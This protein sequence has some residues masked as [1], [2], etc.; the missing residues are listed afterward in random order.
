M[1]QKRAGNVFSRCIRNP[2][3]IFL[4]LSKTQ[5][6]FFMRNCF[7]S[8]ATGQ[9]IYLHS[10]NARCLQQEYGSLENCPETISASIV[11]IKR[12]FMTEVIFKL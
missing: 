4:E 1:G 5:V 3:F 8:A 7:L 11:A 2:G 9:H 6:I 10:V 12:M